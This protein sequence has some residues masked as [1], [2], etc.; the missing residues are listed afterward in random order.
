MEYSEEA[1][2]CFCDG[3]PDV[4]TAFSYLTDGCFPVAPGCQC[5]NGTRLDVHGECVPTSD[6]G[7]HLIEVPDMG[8]PLWGL[9]VSIIRSLGLQ[10]F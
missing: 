9:P 4:A 5:P 3:Y 6:C 8:Y 10:I 7:C 2:L 1:S